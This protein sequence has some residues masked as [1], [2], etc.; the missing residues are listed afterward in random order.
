MLRMEEELGSAALRLTPLEVLAGSC[1]SCFGPKVPGKRPNEPD[2][3]I[4][5]DANFQQR[6]HLAASAAWRGDTG[7]L[8]N[9]FLSP[10]QVLSWKTKMEHA[11]NPNK[12]DDV[13]DPCSAQ[14]TAANNTRGGQT[15]RG[16]DETGLMGI[17]CR[18]DIL[19]KFISIVQSGER[20]AER[21]KF[22]TSVFHSYVHQWACQLKY[23]PRLNDDWGL[24]DGEGLERVWAS[25]AS[26]VGALRYSTKAHRLCSLALR[27]RHINEGK[28]K[29]SAKWLLTRFVSSKKI[30]NQSVQK[31]NTLQQKN[32]M[33]TLEYFKGQW[34]RQRDCQLRAM[35]TEDS[36]MLNQTINRLIELEEQHRE[37]E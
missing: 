29:V 36:Q 33:Y 7:V 10:S 4:C 12:K 32:R 34:N 24:S 37:A 5:L 20:R 17:A 14:H 26:L 25:L 13:V 31:L 9:V 19:L 35:V 30:N 3:I 23:N 2:H 22:G 1:P 28:R 6:R 8:P 11:N 15:W 21:L 18:H 16:C 27:T